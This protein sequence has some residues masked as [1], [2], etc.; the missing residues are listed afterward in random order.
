[1]VLSIRFQHV[2][3]FIYAALLRRK[4][5]KR[6]IKTFF[7][8]IIVFCILLTIC[9]IYLTKHVAAQEFSLIQP[10]DRG[11]YITK[12]YRFN[13]TAYNHERLRCPF[14]ERRYYN[15]GTYAGWLYLDSSLPT[16]VRRNYI[17]VTYGGYVTIHPSHLQSL[18]N[19]S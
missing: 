19:N 14:P 17:D 6:G 12:V 11:K 10:A 4:K 1:M 13:C 8:S 5:M 2:H 16:D 18:E 15:D 7:S 9:P 3:I